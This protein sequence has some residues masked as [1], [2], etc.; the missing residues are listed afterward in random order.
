MTQVTQFNAMR[1]SVDVAAIEREAR[2]LRAEMVRTVAGQF[3]AYL[4]RR[5]AR[6]PGKVQA[7]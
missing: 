5:F 3:A 2:R 7:A 6:Q 1:S 4:R